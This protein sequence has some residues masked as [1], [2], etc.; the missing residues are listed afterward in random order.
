MVFSCLTYWLAEIP[1]SKITWTLLLHLAFPSLHSEE[2]FDAEYLAD[3]HL[4]IWKFLEMQRHKPLS[5][6][7]KSEVNDT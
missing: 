1:I 3:A 2:L 4:A 7:E 5:L 6:I